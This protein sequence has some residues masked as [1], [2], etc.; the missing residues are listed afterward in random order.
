MIS[1]LVRVPGFLSQLRCSED[2]VLRPAILDLVKVF[3]QGPWMGF[4]SQHGCCTHIPR[5]GIS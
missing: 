2:R 5:W 4:C 3:I 1:D